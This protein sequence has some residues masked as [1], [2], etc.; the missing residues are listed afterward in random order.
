LVVG[1]GINQVWS[2]LLS[3]VLTTPL[4]AGFYVVY[5]RQ[6][7]G[8]RW[9]FGDFFSGFKRWGAL[10]GVAALQAVVQLVLLVPMFVLFAVLLTSLPSLIG[11]GGPGAGGPGPVWNGLMG[12]TAG[13]FVVL[14]P[15]WIFL[16][17]RLFFF[18][19]LLIMDRGL[20]AM[21]A[22]KANWE[23]SRGHF[24]GLFGAS[25]VIGLIILGGVLL[26]LVG[27]LF[28][29]PLALLMQTAGYLFLAGRRPPLPAPEPPYRY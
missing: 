14:L 27:V 28:T 25:F 15:V 26:C 12:A 22:L 29:L 4:Y 9:S 21:D 7:D 8:R 1:N 5:L 17:I 11:P 13:F 18:A 2:L 20:G 3:I 16:Y 6:L 10:A 23:L 24:W 19:P